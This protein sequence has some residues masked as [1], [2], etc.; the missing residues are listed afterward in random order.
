MQ[1]LLPATSI[2]RRLRI[3]Q[4]LETRGLVALSYGVA[5]CAK[6]TKAHFEVV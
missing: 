5:Q 3:M 4:Q 2:A 6:P 1:I